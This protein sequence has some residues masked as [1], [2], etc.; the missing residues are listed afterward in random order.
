MNLLF[1]TLISN[2]ENM[3]HLCP[4]ANKVNKLLWPNCMYSWILH[5]NKNIYFTI[6]QICATL[7]A[8]NGKK[9]WLPYQ[10]FYQRAKSIQTL[11]TLSKK[12]HQSH[13]YQRL[14]LCS[15]EAICPI[16][17]LCVSVSIKGSETNTGR[18]AQTKPTWQFRKTN[19]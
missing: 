1:N 11:E 13:L 5:K 12:S 17:G 14:Q 9:K 7:P 18:T 10:T 15:V 19:F 6:S 16:F 3:P 2:I 4:S 8:K